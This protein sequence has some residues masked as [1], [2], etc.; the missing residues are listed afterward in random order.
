[1]AIRIFLLFIF[2]TLCSRSEAAD[3]KLGLLHG[4]AEIFSYEI[5]VV[6]L[7][8]NYAPGEHT[9]EVVSMGD[10][11]QERILNLLHRRSDILNVFFTGYSRTREER[12][13]Q[14]DVPL[15]RGLLGHRVFMIREDHAEKFSQV[16]S[17]AD[18]QALTIGSGVNW[19]DTDI[20]RSAGFTVT[21]STYASL[22]LMLKRGRFDGFN[23]GVHE[24]VIELGEHAGE[25]LMIESRLMVAYKFDYFLY[26][27]K[28]DVER[29]R[30]LTLGLRRAYENG[31]FIKNFNSHPAI[32][33]M[34]AAI[35]PE[36]RQ[37]FYIDNP[38]LSD[39]VK[40]I[41]ESYWHKF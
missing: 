4:D 26:L 25:G 16:S 7:A 13:L 1:M 31:A 37:T 35:H 23:R 18:L 17:L 29:Y 27:G 15:T 24:A 9:L 3:F 6:Q 28:D 32:K 12:F 40:A 8:L 30:I 10:A 19:P 34:V 36:Q 22:W 20:L 21:E 38:Y 39:K 14:V 2:V 11:T 41:A 33:E 5:S